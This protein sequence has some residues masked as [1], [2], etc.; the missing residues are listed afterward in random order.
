MTDTTDRLE[1]SFGVVR[2][3]TLADVARDLKI[4]PSTVSRALDPNRSTMVNKATR[5]K[6]IESAERLG[7]RPDIQARSLMT[8]RTQTI[9]VIAADLGNR[10]LTPILHGVA[11]RVSVEG[12]V[13]IIAET[14]DDSR[15]LDDLIDHMLSRRVDAMIVVGARRGDGPSIERAARMVPMVVAARPLQD[16]SVP[17]VTH[18]DRRGGEMIGQHFA[19]LGHRVVAQLLGPGA[20]L[21]FPLRNEGFTSAIESAGLRQLPAI[22]EALRPTYDEGARLMHRLLDVSSDVPTAVFAHNDPMAIGAMSVI[23]ER[24]LRI[25]EDISIAGYNDM[26]LTSLINPGL[27]TV[28]YPGW[29]V[30]H[31]AAEVALRLFAGEEAVESVS[32]N[33]VFKPRGSTAPLP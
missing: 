13:P 20:V 19:D 32:L 6:I 16:I 2:R 15:V 18:D 11:S 30:G 14:N 27:T 24:G 31:A 12:I 29:E 5:E 28:R 8:G 7:Y 17:V 21:N 1:D 3:A 9:V 25:P 26:P 4:S 23:R 10:W 33:P 22:D